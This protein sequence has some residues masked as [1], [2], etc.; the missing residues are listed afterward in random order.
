MRDMDK[1][2][3][4]PES[5]GCSLFALLERFEDRLKMLCGN[6]DASILNGK[7][8]TSPLITKSEV[9]MEFIFFTRSLTRRSP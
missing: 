9:T 8:M 1:P 6:P 2:R 5:S 7:A 3:P 4:V